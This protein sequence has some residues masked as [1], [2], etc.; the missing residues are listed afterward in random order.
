MYITEQYVDDQIP[1]SSLL[2]EGPIDY[3]K[4]KFG[5][6]L[7]KLNVW[8]KSV[9]ARLKKHKINEMKAKAM[10]KKKANKYIKNIGKSLAKS[11]ATKNYKA[12]GKQFSTAM[13]DGYS[14]IK[15]YVL[16]ISWTRFTA[17]VAQ[18]IMLAL[19]TTLAIFFMEAILTGS[20]FWMSTTATTNLTMSWG[21]EKAFQGGVWLAYYLM[22]FAI[23]IIF[24]PIIK[25]S[26]RL[27]AVSTR[28]GTSWGVTMTVADVF[29]STF[30]YFNTGCTDIFKKHL[31]PK[32]IWGSLLVN[33]L[34]H[35][36]QNVITFVGDLPFI[37]K[38]LG[39]WAW[40][41]SVCI[42][43][44]WE[45]LITPFV[46]NGTQAF[47]ST[48]GERVIGFKKDLTKAVVDPI[49][50]AYDKSKSWLTN[51]LKALGLNKTV[52]YLPS[53]PNIS[54]WPVIKQ[55]IKLIKD[56]SES[57]RK[58]LHA[59]GSRHRK[60]PVSD[61]AYSLKTSVGAPYIVA[62]GARG[63]KNAIVNTANGLKTAGIATTDYITKHLPKLDPI[64]HLSY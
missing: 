34:L 33:G 32:A 36:V 58:K 14:L 52:S 31:I 28:I 51:M 42:T 59:I 55:I 30:Y 16:A 25:E 41:I 8:K 45:N 48:P 23:S 20:I 54:K 5:S 2:L 44:L 7:T 29:R 26:M 53:L 43:S 50:I 35:T 60:K 49:K 9:S 39:P 11:Y 61:D 17:K 6:N 13:M 12:V 27:V 1:M 63:V 47:D 22:S 21:Q 38:Y 46:F 40:G 57:L 37:K 4:S 56:A 24:V 64:L 3:L 10:L 18:G 15:R 19:I 62:V